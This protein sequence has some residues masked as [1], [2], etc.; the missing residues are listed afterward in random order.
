MALY[1]KQ[2]RIRTGLGV[3]PFPTKEG[4]IMGVGWA[5]LPQEI[6]ELISKKLTIYFDY[7]RFRCVC[8]SVPETPLHLPPQFPLLMLSPKS[9][10]D[11][12]TN[13]LHHLNLPLSSSHRTRICGSSYGWL[14]ILHEISEV[15]LLNPITC[16]TLSLPS[17]YTLPKFV[18]KRLKCNS[19]SFLNKVV[20]SSSPS[21]SSDFVAFAIL[22]SSALAFYRKGHD[23]WVLF[24]VNGYHV[25]M[26]VVSKNNLFYAVSMEGTIAVCDVEGP[27]VSVIETT[28]SV[29]LG[30]QIYY[31]VF[32]GEDMLLVSS[33]Q[34]A[35]FLILKMNW[36]TLKWEKIQTLGGKMLF[37]ESRSS[38]SFS[39]TDF[40]RCPTKLIYF[41]NDVSS[42]DELGIFSLGYPI[43]VTPSL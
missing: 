41:T 7:L 14:V 34:T 2:S 13:K 11:P 1:E 19:N 23:S 31:V 25:W 38:F 32:S 10:L 6:I 4:K 5:E 21:L 22:N 16:V 28:N 8:R 9:F 33:Y 27:R 15:R 24:N 39:A 17:L 20:L 3:P 12:S 40:A 35:W 43:W 18:R 26:D 36:N 42:K 29:N 37:L 30:N